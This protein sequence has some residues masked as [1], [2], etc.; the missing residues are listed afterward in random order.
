M[1]KPTS[2]ESLLKRLESEMHT[3]DGRT[4]RVCRDENGNYWVIDDAERI[5]SL[6]EFGSDR[7]V[8][9]RHLCERERAQAMREL[10]AAMKRGI[11][12]IVRAFG[13]VAQPAHA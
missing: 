11:G 5:V 2:I 10:G 3:A 7:S 12:R 4:A 1:T 6:S 13:A 9:A 8:S